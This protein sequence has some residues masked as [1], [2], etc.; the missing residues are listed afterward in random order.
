MPTLLRRRYQRKTVPLAE[1]VV[2][3]FVLLL[4]AGIVGAFVAAYRPG[5][6][7]LFEPDPAHLQATSETPEARIAGQMMPVL[8]PAWVPLR[9]AESRSPKAVA[10]WTGPA[11]DAFLSHG[12][13]AAYRGG[14]AT[15]AG[16]GGASATVTVYDMA[17]PAAAKAVCT[18]RRPTSATDVS[19]G[20]SG[21]AAGPRVGFWSGRLYTEVEAA[22]PDAATAA[23]EVARATAAG[24]LSYGVPVARATEQAAPA[25]PSDASGTASLFPRLGGGWIA[26]LDIKRFD[27]DTLYEKIDGKAGMF[28][29]YLF[30][31]LR[32]GTYQ[33]PDSGG[34][35]DVYLYDMG[36]PVNA[37]GVYRLERSPDAK[38][39][40][41][42]RE[43]YTSGASVFFWKGK[44]YVNVLGPSDA[45]GAAEA[46]EQLASAIEKAIA[47]DGSPLWAATVFP[48]ADQRPGSLTYKSTDALGHSF[49]RQV[50]LAEYVTKGT[51]YQL[52]IHRARD[53]AAAKAI[54]D[55]YAEAIRKYNK[56]LTRKPVPGG[57]LIVSESLGVFEAAFHKGAL[58]GG[59]TECDDG[60]LAEKKAE[61]FASGIDEAAITASVPPPAAAAQ[62]AA[63]APAQTPTEPTESEGYGE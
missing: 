47:D 31:E 2:G 50:F 44:Y 22:G 25:N 8:P 17:E 43:G 46:A 62:P 23:M 41:L 12:L 7:K 11:T 36:E 32:F 61:A 63:S 3:V 49:L 53:A 37:F 56:V 4:A 28:L 42:G 34:A 15:V 33:K 20:R 58:F 48:K 59:V 45:P 52:F 9:G 38:V 5:E 24:Q 27:K 18:E 16:N 57:E 35:F 26:P 14:F 54:F 55:Q 40:P 21:W 60:A 6:R 51:T 1:I 13:V 39:R 10:A 29:S 30:A 19:V